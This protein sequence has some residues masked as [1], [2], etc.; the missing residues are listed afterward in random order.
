[1]QSVSLCGDGYESNGPSQT[2][3]REE[4][5]DGNN[6]SGDGCSSTCTIENEYECIDAAGNKRWG[7]GS[8][9]PKCG[10]GIIDDPYA[11]SSNTALFPLQV[12][13][14]GNDTPSSTGIVVEECD[15]GA[16]NY[17]LVTLTGSVPQYP[18]SKRC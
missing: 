9:T 14:D 11:Q 18:C 7:P 4:C 3:A 1:M 8:C 2:D 12:L 6:I 17:N 15:M 16:W 5:D 13:P 10:N